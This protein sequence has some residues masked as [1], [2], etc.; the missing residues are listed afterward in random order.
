MSC[1]NCEYK[2]KV[3][4]EHISRWE[5]EVNRLDEKIL[6]LVDIGSSWEKIADG[7]YTAISSGQLSDVLDAKRDYVKFRT[8]HSRG[9]HE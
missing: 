2:D 7:L 5:K 1:K 9:S 6:E 3:Y 4:A 8:L